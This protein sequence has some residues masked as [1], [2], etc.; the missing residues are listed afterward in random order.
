MEIKL[1]TESEKFNRKVMCRAWSI[2]HHVK[3]V[4]QSRRCWE[5][6]LTAKRLLSEV[7][8]S[9]R[10]IKLNKKANRMKVSSIYLA[11]SKI[12][13]LSNPPFYIRSDN[14]MVLSTGKFEWRYFVPFTPEEQEKEKAKQERAGILKFKKRKNVEYF[15]NELEIENRMK[16]LN[17]IMEMKRK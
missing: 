7:K 11:V 10:N 12:N 16:K 5:D 14:R 8:K 15:G 2:P 13:L 4:M 17:P 9:L 1:E 3:L 6:G